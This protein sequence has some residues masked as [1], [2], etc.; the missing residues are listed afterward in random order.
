M[1]IISSWYLLDRLPLILRECVRLALTHTIQYPCERKSK[2][3]DICDVLEW[4][5]LVLYTRVG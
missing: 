4:D 3:T 1:L 2:M 5:K